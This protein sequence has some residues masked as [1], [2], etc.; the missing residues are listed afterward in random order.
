M[1]C[2]GMWGLTSSGAVTVNVVNST[3]SAVPATDPSVLQL[4]IWTH[5]VQTFSSTNGN[6]LYINGYLVTTTSAS[7]GDAVGPYIFIGL[8]PSGCGFCN[9]GS[10][11][12]GQFY[13]SVDEFRV[14]GLELTAADVCRLANP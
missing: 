11:A 3:N 7:T 12:I 9:H 1:I 13:G 2:L 5:V 10:I 4:N 6:S 14:F 8:T